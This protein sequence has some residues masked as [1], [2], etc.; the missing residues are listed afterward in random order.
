LF[1]KVVIADHVSA[2]A[3]PVFDAAH[4]GIAPTTFY[5][6]LAM[7]AYSQQLYFDFSGYSDMGLGL[8]RMLN[9]K[10]P[11]NFN[12]PYKAANIIDFWRRWHMT[13]SSFLRDYLYIPLGGSRSGTWRRHL[14]LFITMLL[15]GLWHG[16]GWGFVI[17]GGLHGTY[18]VM[19]HTWRSLRKAPKLGEDKPHW[20]I[21]EANVTFTFLAVMLGWVF[22]R[23]ADWGTSILML[24]S[25]AGFGELGFAEG[26]AHNSRSLLLCVAI[27][28]IARY[29]PNSQEMLASQDPAL[30]I[31]KTTWRWQWQFTP[32]W[33]V[34]TAVVAC[35]ALLQLTHATEF[36]YFQF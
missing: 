26:L 17:W 28:L 24:K 15:G 7:L 13:L 21:H 33:A 25:M 12:S 29:A 31:I 5:A 3:S 18:L 32:R 27:Y 8:A 19:N 34:V 6:W 35:I 2:Y 9:F 11:L 14:N 10:L 23:A 22:F 20:F 16:A 1:K 4:K 30:P 36:L